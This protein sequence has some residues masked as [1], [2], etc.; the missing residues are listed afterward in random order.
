MMQNPH[1]VVHLHS[2]RTFEHWTKR[3]G[4]GMHSLGLTQQ[5]RTWWHLCGP[6]GSYRTRP[7]GTGTGSS[8]CRQH[9]CVRVCMLS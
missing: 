6:S 4:H 1:E 3:C 9:R 2:H 8:S 7:S 5:W